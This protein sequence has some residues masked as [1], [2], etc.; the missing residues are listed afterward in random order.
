MLANHCS[1]SSNLVRQNF[2]Y[3]APGIRRRPGASGRPPAVG[4]RHT[5]TVV[6]VGRAR[7]SHGRASPGTRAGMLSAQQVT[8]FVFDTA[9]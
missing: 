8:R 2:E 5:V 4:R 7:D 1:N 6:R 3:P 9:G